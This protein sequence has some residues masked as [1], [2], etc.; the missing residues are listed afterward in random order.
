MGN[1]LEEIENEFSRGRGRS[2]RLSPLDWSLA[3]GWENRGVPLSLVLRAMGDVCKSNSAKHRPETIGSL[4][5]FTPAVEKTFAEWQTS[6][7]GKQIEQTSAPVIEETIMGNAS[8]ADYG[9]ENIAI[10]D[11]IAFDLAG[12]N[13]LPELLESTVA[14]TRGEILALIDDVN[15]KHL[16]GDKIEARLTELRA[17]LDIGLI[18][19]VTDDERAEIIADVKKEYGRFTLMPGVQEKVLIRKLYNRFG[20]PEITLYAL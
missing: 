19:S 1:F 15:A 8:A 2:S 9:N 12:N 20:L 4:R 17:E 3:Q 5:Y 16:C 18:A 10:L 6:Q 13:G 7:I 14:K 11:R